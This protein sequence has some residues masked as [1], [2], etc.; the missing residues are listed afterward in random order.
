MAGVPDLFFTP[1]MENCYMGTGAR[2]HRKYIGNEAVWIHPP[3]QTSRQLRG[4]AASLLLRQSVLPQANVSL[5]KRL[6][7]VIQLVFVVCMARQ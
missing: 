4:Q 7:G 1:R 3:T 6:S 2:S 5:C